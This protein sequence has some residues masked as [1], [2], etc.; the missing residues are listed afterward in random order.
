L[1]GQPLD[2]LIGED[3]RQHRRTRRV[4]AAAIVGLAALAV[5]ASVFGVI[6]SQQRDEARRQ[7][8]IAVEQQQIAT[9]QRDQARRRLVQLNVA[10]GLRVADAGDV[11]AALL[12]FAEA[13]QLEADHPVEQGLLRTRLA[14]LA[15]RHPRLAQVWSAAAPI[16]GVGFTT[17]AAWVVVYPREGS[18]QAW[19]AQTASAA[20]KPPSSPVV[21][22]A[23]TPQGRRLLT[24]DTDGAH[25]WDPLTG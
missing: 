1:Q 25:L 7:E 11:S 20:F 22:V 14:S 5:A 24:V 6:A 2:E 17:D 4:A 16:G 23:V 19:D 8:R 9:E 21:D 13:A 10:N 18:V 3:V 12:W 15:G